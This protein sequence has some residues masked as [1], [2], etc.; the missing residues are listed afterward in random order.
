M[1]SYEESVRDRVIALQVFDIDVELLFR[2]DRHRRTR[3]E[4]ISS[5]SIRRDFRLL[6]NSM[7]SHD[8]F[9]S[10]EISFDFSRFVHVW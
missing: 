5:N 3:I 7:M 1:H 10:M 9:V 4:R 8:A 2:L 6:T